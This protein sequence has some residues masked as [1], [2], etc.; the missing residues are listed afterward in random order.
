MQPN[1]NMPGAGQPVGPAK[2]VN[3]VNPVNPTRPVRPAMPTT[4]TT[5]AA[6]EP[7]FDNG[8]SVV[9][10]KGGKKA[11]WILAIVLLLIVAAGGVGF[12]VW[13]YMDGNVQK[14]ALNSQISALKQQNNDLQ[15]KLESNGD[16]DVNG[17]STGSN[18]NPIIKAGD[19]Y[20]YRVHYESP[21]YSVNAEDF[22]TINIGVEDGKVTY[23]GINY[24]GNR[25]VE[26]CEINGLTG[27]I[28]NIVEFTPPAQDASGLN[29]GF[30]M[31]DGSVEYLSYMDIMENNDFS[32][33]KLNIDGNIVNAVTVG[34][35]SSDPEVIGS[36]T[37]TVFVMSD[38]SLVEFNETMLK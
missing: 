14:D 36:G 5:S 15:E 37:V 32:V 17:N 26:T 18:V 30:I 34:H 20:V 23:C 3:P 12:G 19:G 27:N 29:I 1:G 6:G 4:P 35:G 21:K 16:I 24:S 11:G 10:G 28:Y 38:G 25:E 31:A 8:P 13:A 9:D 7:T 33:K 22:K 2:P